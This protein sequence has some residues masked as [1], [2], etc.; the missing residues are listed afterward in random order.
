MKYGQV[1]ISKSDDHSPLNP[2]EP[3]FILR[4]TDSLAC[5]AIRQYANL[6]HTAGLGEHAGSITPVLRMFEEWQ[7][8]NPEKV[9]APDT[10]IT[11]QTING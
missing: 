9:T 1:A 7:R 10:T 8:Q 6:C 11:D 4:A 5:A 3:V 2:E